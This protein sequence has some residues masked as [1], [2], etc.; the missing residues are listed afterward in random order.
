VVPVSPVQPTPIVSPPS[1]VVEETPVETS[2]V[3][4]TPP[5]ESGKA[6]EVKADE[7]RAA[8]VKAQEEKAR[9]EKVEE[10]VKLK[11]EAKLKE[12]QKAREVKAQEEK[13]AEEKLKTE[14]K[15]RAEEKVKAEEKAREEAKAKE[16]A[17]LK[18]EAKAREE[19]LKAEEKVKAEEKA[20]EEKARAE[21]KVKA[22]EKAKEEERAKEKTGTPENCFENPET[23][24]SNRFE[25]CGYPG[26]KNTGVEGN[27][28]G[29]ECLALPEYT[30]SRSIGTAKTKIEGKLV[31][32][33]LG[34]SESGFDVNAAEVTFNKDCLLVTGDGQEGPVIKQDE[35]GANLL[36]ENSTIRAEG[37]KLP[38]SYEKA[39][40]NN[41]GISAGWKIVNSRVEDCGECVSGFG[42]IVKSYVISNEYV[43]EE[44]HGLHREDW[45]LN[46]ETAVVKESTMFNP[47]DQTSDIFMDSN[48]GSGRIACVDK[49]TVEGS[50][51]A[52]GGTS[53]EMCGKEDSKG[54]SS[55]TFVDNRIPRCETT[56]I[57]KNSGGEED[58]SGPDF[59]GGDAHGYMPHGGA[60]GV[61]AFADVGTVTWSGNYWDNSL[62]PL[63]EP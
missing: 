27:S 55:F 6:K 20:R 48:N 11:E 5:V 18:E 38:Y 40:D 37:P 57:V 2:P 58:C 54:S 33:K 9:E 15:A 42:E 7:E 45:Y 13:A 22:E 21:E 44:S 29:T 28:G 19:K 39:V 46:D 17:K 4:T 10:E 31:K 34:S 30:G 16:E 62:E 26:P 50:L 52:G 8:E 41:Y 24:G 43:G 63:A 49:L 51:L 36:V 12:E 23:E 59:E 14:E 60:E 1:E 53:I 56:P 35:H 25:A 32:V 47:T 3:E 61:A